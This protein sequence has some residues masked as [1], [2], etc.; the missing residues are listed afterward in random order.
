M[1]NYV[2][3]LLTTEALAKQKILHKMHFN[4]LKITAIL[5]LIKTV[6][7]TG[8]NIYWALLFYDFCLHQL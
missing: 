4:V 7:I 3:L 6:L 8:A 1:K 5:E 2:H